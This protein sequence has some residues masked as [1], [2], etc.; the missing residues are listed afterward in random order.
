MPLKP[1]PAQDGAPNLPPVQRWQV[2][3]ASPA[4]LPEVPEEPRESH[5]L[6]DT[7]VELPVARVGA[8]PHLVPTPHVRPVQDGGGEHR[9]P[10]G[11]VAVRQNLEL[12]R[13]VRQESAEQGRGVGAQADASAAAHDIAVDPEAR[14]VH[15]DLGPVH[16]P[17]VEPAHATA[18]QR[19]HRSGRRAGEAEAPRQVV[20]GPEGEREQ[21]GTRLCLPEAVGDLV[22]RPV[23][24]ADH[25]HVGPVLRS[26]A[27]ELR[28][29]PRALRLEPAPH[30]GGREERAQ[31]V[32]PPAGAGGSRV[33]DQDA[34]P[35]RTGGAQHVRAQ[36]WRGRMGVEPI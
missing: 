6:E 33:E 26:G 8:R 25:D 16:L 32:A 21:Q 4:H 9:S 14:A 7:E 3:L 27:R 1:F 20:P 17:G 34:V 18:P 31:P 19:L 12:C 30:P 29:V 13:A 5:H 35:R 11:E 10:V 2:A 28:R 22:H 15:E 23:A 36:V 24:A